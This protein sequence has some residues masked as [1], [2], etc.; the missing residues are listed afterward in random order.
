MGHASGKGL[1]PSSVAAIAEVAEMGSAPTQVSAGRPSPPALARPL[2]RDHDCRASRK[3]AGGP[4]SSYQ[5]LLHYAWGPEREEGMEETPCAACKAI[6]DCRL[7]HLADEVLER[8][9]ELVHS[10]EG[11]VEGALEVDFEGS[12]GCSVH[13]MT[14]M[15]GKGGGKVGS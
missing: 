11:P 15:M 7:H 9:G 12:V 13:T 8:Q 5:G 6:R 3:R 2:A 14:V 4:T 10:E 1:L